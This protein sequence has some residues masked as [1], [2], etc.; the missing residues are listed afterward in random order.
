M[1]S[2]MCIRDRLLIDG[3][4]G[5]GLSLWV[6]PV[7]AGEDPI[8]RRSDA[9]MNLGRGQV[10]YVQLLWPVAA[11]LILRVKQGW[12]LALAAFFGLMLSAHF[13]NLSIVILTSILAAGFAAIAAW[14]PKL[15]LTL[16]FALAICSLA[17]APVLGFISSM[18]DAELMRKI[19]LS[20]DCL[21]Y[22]SPSPR[23]AT[24]SRMPSSA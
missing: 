10:S 15:G 24:L 17:F 8:Q 13:N 3:A 2:E 4:S 19:P 16:A 20:W 7:S 18:L 23:D 1:G 5:F 11:L 22:T 12:I 21:L 14:R 6:D 9:E